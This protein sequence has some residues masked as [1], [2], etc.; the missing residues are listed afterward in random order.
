MTLA[1]DVNAWRCNIPRSRATKQRMEID[2]ETRFITIVTHSVQMS[3]YTVLQMYFL[4]SYETVA[5]PCT[6]YNCAAS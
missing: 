4:R 6:L 5:T 2:I 3:L 1:K